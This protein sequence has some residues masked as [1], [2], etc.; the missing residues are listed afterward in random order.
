MSDSSLYVPSPCARQDKG[1]SC[2]FSAEFQRYYFQKY[3]RMITCDVCIF[4]RLYK[5]TPQF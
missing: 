5:P 1:L 4:C 3:D 2:Q